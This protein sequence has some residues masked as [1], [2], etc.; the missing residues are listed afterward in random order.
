MNKTP[1][2][3]CNCPGKDIQTARHLLVECSIYWFWCIKH[4]QHH[5]IPHNHFQRTSRRINRKLTLQ[6][7]PSMYWPILKANWQMVSICTTSVNTPWYT[8][9]WNTGCNQWMQ[10][11][12]SLH[13]LWHLV[14]LTT[15]DDRHLGYNLYRYSTVLC[16]L[17]SDII[18]Y[19]S[20][21][22]TE[23]DC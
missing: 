1:S 10:I 15:I 9:S 8:C 5:K 13:Y 22:S 21:N 19:Y 6:N 12:R 18:N 16:D 17:K 7:D 4:C 23:R 3:N 2:P 11:K 20:F 14:V